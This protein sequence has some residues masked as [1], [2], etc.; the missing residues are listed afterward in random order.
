MVD[1][2]TS[3]EDGLFRVKSCPDIVD[4]S[5]DDLPSSIEFEFEFKTK[6]RHQ[7][8]LRVRSAQSRRD[9]QTQ[10]YSCGALD[11]KVLLDPTTPPNSVSPG[12]GSRQSSNP[13]LNCFSVIE[14]S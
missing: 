8:Q 12:C 13:S 1:R 9:S 6:I 2:S 11:G 7:V 5:N 3:L 14:V 4:Q 10:R